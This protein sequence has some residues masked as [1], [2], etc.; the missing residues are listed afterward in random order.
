MEKETEITTL[1]YWMDVSFF[2]DLA[3]TPTVVF[4]PRGIIQ[5]H[6]A[7]EHIYINEL[8]A[9]AKTV[10]QVGLNFCKREKTWPPLCQDNYAPPILCDKVPKTGPN[11]RGRELGW[12]PPCHPS[13][14]LV[15]YYVHA[16]K[17]NSHLPTHFS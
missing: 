13:I 15:L 11:V 9:Y 17:L 16:R 7:D 8:L 10:A 4:S 2:V 12:A 14:Y 3:H 5:V 1:T 6:S